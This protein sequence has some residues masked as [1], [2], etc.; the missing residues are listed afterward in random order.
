MKPIKIE[1]DQFRFELDESGCYRLDSLPIQCAEEEG[2]TGTL[3]TQ[4]QRVALGRFLTEIGVALATPKPRKRVQVE[5]GI[6][7]KQTSI[8]TAHRT[9]LGHLRCWVGE[10]CWDERLRS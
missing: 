2:M 10:C 3:S 5:C 4:E 7:H 8:V 1:N 6:C 9:N